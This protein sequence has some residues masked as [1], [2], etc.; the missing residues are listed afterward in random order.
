RRQAA[1][2]DR[3]AAMGR[4]R[5]SGW[6][7]S[8]VIWAGSAGCGR[9]PEAARLAA[10]VT[11]PEPFLEGAGLVVMEAE[12]AT[13][14]APGT[15]VAAPATW[16]A[17]AVTAA[18][19]G[20]AMEATPSTLGVNTGDATIGPRRDYQVRFATPG[21]YQL[22][23]LASGPTSSDDSFHAGRDGTPLTFGQSGF[24]VPRTWTWIN[25]VGTRR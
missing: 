23:M 6:M 4:W 24:I 14:E 19:G 20:V 13:G 9:S 10:A 21:T 1:R 3:G 11:S 5:N 25:T 16:T 17:R 12:H 2:V 8:L 22:W 18:S 7:A 15:G